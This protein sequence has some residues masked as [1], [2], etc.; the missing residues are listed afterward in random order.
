MLPLFRHLGILAF[1]KVQP[2]ATRITRSLIGG[3]VVGV[4][5]LTAYVALLLAIGFYL[6]D[7][8]GPVYAALI[9]AGVMALCSIVVILVIQA[10]NKATERRMEARRRAAK[11][12]LPDPMT[13]QLLAGIPAM[14]KGR[15]LLTTAA[16]AAL[17][18]GVAKM[19]GIGR[20]ERDD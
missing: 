20:D 12:Q 16:I 15:S 5:A 3:A 13:L 11:S 4:L 9:I 2:T 6:S 18:F 14:I 1:G 19:Q 17:V 10:M 7:E 8:L